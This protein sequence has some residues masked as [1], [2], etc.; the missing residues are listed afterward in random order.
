V[1]ENDKAGD[2][3]TWPFDNELV[4]ILNVT[5]G[6][7]WAGQQG[8]DSMALPWKMEIDHVNYWEGI[9]PN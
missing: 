2:H 6:G 4:L 3:S 1:F 5:V 8:V 7:D 9:H